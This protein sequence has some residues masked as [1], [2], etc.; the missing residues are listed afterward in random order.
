MNNKAE[1]D[2]S[3]SNYKNKISDEI[4]IKYL[5]KKYFFKIQIINY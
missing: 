3:Y 4:K 1:I 5:V 2:I